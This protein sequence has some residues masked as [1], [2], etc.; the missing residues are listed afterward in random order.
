MK[1]APEFRDPVNEEARPRD[2]LLHAA[3]AR[4]TGGIS[5][6]AVGQAFQDWLAHLATAPGK[7]AELAQK[8]QRKLTRLA[9][10]LASVAN[11]D[12]CPRCIEPLPQDRRFEHPDWQQWPF[13]V[14]HQSFLLAQQVS[15]RLGLPLAT[16]SLVRRRD[17][18][19]Q[20]RAAEA[21]ARRRN[22]AG[23]FDC[24]PGAVAGRRVLLVDDVTT[25]GAT[26]DACARVLLTQGGA[27]SVWALTFA[28][29]D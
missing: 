16:A 18:P 26:L 8:A 19:P 7:Q 9:L 5:P 24:R 25:T 15:R 3:V 1:P 28:R 21:D 17:T 6:I 10:Y 14:M 4:A 2:A 11:P 22:V 27:S 23:A 29:E 13:N 20:A 12:G